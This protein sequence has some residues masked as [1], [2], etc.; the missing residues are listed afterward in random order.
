MA[1]KLTKDEAFAA[2]LTELQNE[3]PEDQR[4]QVAAALNGSA[5][6]KDAFLRQSDYSRFMDEARAEREAV[7][8]AA[9]AEIA[10]AR[11]IADK[12]NKWGETS[13][14]ELSTATERL[15]QYEATYGPID[16]NNPAKA[17]PGFSKDEVAALLEAK[18]TERSQQMVAFADV[19]T[20]LKMSHRDSFKEPL[21]T[22]DL[23]KFAADNGITDLTRAYGLFTQPRI[24]ER[25][26]QEHAD[27]LKRARDEGAREALSNVKLPIG[28]SR[29]GNPVIDAINNRTETPR[30][31]RISSAVADLNTRIGARFTPAT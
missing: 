13:Y 9:E 18:L 8:T 15:R 20:D 19:L 27:A 23:L 7:R 17:V 1:K 22:Q 11:D 24:E 12:W 31:E 25:R 10:T 5:K 28:G 16:P 2:F 14:S 29:M 21:P 6:A 3:F 26:E 30:G 4:E